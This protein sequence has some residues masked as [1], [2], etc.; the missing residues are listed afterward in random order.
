MS[1]LQTITRDAIDPALAMLPAV[2][3]T[4]QAR[5]QILANGLQE[6]RL[7]HRRQL[8]GNPPKPEGPAAGLYQFEQGGGCTGVLR[9]QAARFWM[10]TACRARQC[11]PTPGALWQC[12]QHDDILATVAARLL[13]F[14]DPKRLPDLGDRDGAWLLYMRTWRPGKP[15][16]DTW[17]GFYAQALQFVTETAS[18]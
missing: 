16:P 7:V 3:D 6:S 13:L 8:V 15:K 18:A 5:V 12:I 2:M 4:P 10:V 9:H 17:P 1:L 14:T 11:D